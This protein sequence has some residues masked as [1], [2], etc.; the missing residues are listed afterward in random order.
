MSQELGCEAKVYIDEKD[1]QTVIFA[2]PHLFTNAVTLQVI[3]L[4]I[5]A[6][7]AWTP[8]K[9]AEIEPYAVKYYPA[10]FEQKTTD[11]L[12]VAPERTFWEK[13]TILHHEANRPE[14]LEMP[15][16][17]SRHYFYLYRMSMTPVKESAFAHRELLQKVVDF[18]MKFY[19]WAW[20]KYVDA[21]IPGT[22]KLISPYYRFSALQ[23]DYDAMKDMLYGDIP[24][25]EMVMSAVR[26]LEKE[27]N[28]F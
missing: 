9:L 18:K 25:F 13:A 14:H 10:V 12:T 5:G 24:D 2:Y 6:L 1:R 15:Q 11:I 4:E 17:Y 23:T 3:R 20:A 21:A 26:E 28:T 19:P 8:A 22:L 16:R 7:A 27:I